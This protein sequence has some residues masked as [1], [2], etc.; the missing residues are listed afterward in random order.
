MA[1]RP[2]LARSFKMG[3]IRLTERFVKSDPLSNRDEREL[4]KHINRES[5]DYL[6]EII[7]ARLRPRHRH[8][9]HDPQPRRAG[10]RRQAIG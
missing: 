9:R 2:Q 4:I 6:D 10:G 8:E 7:V 1:G 3:V 5:G